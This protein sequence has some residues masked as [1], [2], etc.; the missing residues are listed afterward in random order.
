MHQRRST[1]PLTP[2][3]PEAKPIV[4]LTQTELQIQNTYATYLLKQERRRH[5]VVE[6]TFVHQLA[7]LQKQVDDLRLL[8]VELLAEKLTRKAN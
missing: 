8:Y 1:A 3:I 7:G 5:A 6:G 2:N 4:E